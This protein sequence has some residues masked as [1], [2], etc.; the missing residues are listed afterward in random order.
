MTSRS[1]WPE[2]PDFGGLSVRWRGKRAWETSWLARPPPRPEGRPRPRKTGSRRNSFK[3][4]H[5]RMARDYPLVTPQLSAENTP[6]PTES[7]R[8]APRRPHQRALHLRLH[9]HLP[10][11]F[12]DPG[13][14]RSLS[15]PLSH[16]PGVATFP[17]A[18][19][20][21]RERP[22]PSGASRAR[23]GPRTGSCHCGKASGSRG[24]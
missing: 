2:A 21:L 13:P 5:T 6:H 10:R 3:G 9:R 11:D 19:E 8:H 22:Q 7:P 4:C 1:R 17:T 20:R 16:S 18:S 15:S 23:P 12:P 14:P 24:S